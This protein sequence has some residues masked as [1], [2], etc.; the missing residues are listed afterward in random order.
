MR[1][2]AR[3]VLTLHSTHDSRKPKRRLMQPTRNSG[4]TRS[5]PKMRK[6]EVFKE[7]IKEELCEN[8]EEETFTETSM[9]PRNSVRRISTDFNGEESFDCPNRGFQQ[10]IHSKN[11]I[12]SSISSSELEEL[13][14]DFKKEKYLHSRFLKDIIR[15][16][17]LRRFRSFRNFKIAQHSSLES[18][19]TQGGFQR[20]APQSDKRSSAANLELRLGIEE[21]VEYKLVA[22]HVGQSDHF[23]HENALAIASKTN[24][25]TNPK[26]LMEGCAKAMCYITERSQKIHEQKKCVNNSAENRKEILSPAVLLSACA[27]SVVGAN[28]AFSICT[29]HHGKISI[30]NAG[31][32]SFV[33]LSSKT[34]RYRIKA[35]SHTSPSSQNTNTPAEELKSEKADGGLRDGRTS[36]EYSGRASNGDMVV[37]STSSA[38]SGIPGREIEDL[39]GEFVGDTFHVK[40]M[41]VVFECTVRSLR[42]SC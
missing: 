13:K 20:P 31:T 16:T 8:S 35:R 2:S 5:D 37:L 42:R 14:G 40:Y 6:S 24:G 19:P 18:V 15:R 12:E 10:S 3:K 11:S 23:A 21:F 39:V 41:Q 36:T 9:E 26:N 17:R 33:Y 27:D 25:F 34:G 32:C 4:I 7:E 1:L 38:L 30:L 22:K 28:S 29:L